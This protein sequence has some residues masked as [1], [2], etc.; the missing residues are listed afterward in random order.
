MVGQPLDAVEAA[1]CCFLVLVGQHLGTQVA[2]QDLADGV[3]GSSS[4][5]S[6][7]AGIL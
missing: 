7:R 1:C 2:A 3:L 4:R 5:N 6:M